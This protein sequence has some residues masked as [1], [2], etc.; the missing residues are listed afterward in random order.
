MTGYVV[1]VSSC[2]FYYT[3]EDEVL[4]SFSKFRLVVQEEEGIALDR[5]NVRKCE[6]ECERS[7]L[8]KI[9]GVKLANFTGLKN[10]LS[11]LWSQEEELKLV[12]LGNSFFQFIF[13]NK[14]NANR[15]MQ[16]RP[17]F[18]DNQMIVLQHW[19]SDLKNEDLSFKKGLMGIQICGLPNH[20]SS[21][22]VCWKLGKLFPSCLNVVIPEH[23][24]KEG[25][26]IRLLVELYLDRPLL[27]GTKI[28][29]HHELVWI[30][31]RYEHLPTFYFYYEKK[32]HPDKSCEQ[33]VQDSKGNY[34]CEDQHGEWLRATVGRGVRK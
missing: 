5:K 30:D 8:G 16:K 19:R 9:W 29:L 15:V 31:F 33:K 3:M 21:K 13:A 4:N 2:R 7:L 22:K 1:L 23:G 14:E 6:E 26:L 20:W 18:F 34:I 24:S 12:E 27:G 32:G 17:W 28:K 11:L 10:T 25:K